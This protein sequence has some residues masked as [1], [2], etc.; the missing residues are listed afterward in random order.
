MIFFIST[1]FICIFILFIS[2]KS[3]IV[4]QIITCI[5]LLSGILLYVN[6]QDNHYRIM[7]YNTENYFDTFND[8]LTRDDDF[9]PTGKQF[10]GKTKFL[11][12]RNNLFK[13]ILALGEGN[14]P[15]AVGL[16]EIENRYVLNELCFNTPLRKYNYKIIH[17]ES[18][19]PRGID[20]ALL[21][22]TDFL[23]PLSSRAIH[24]SYSPNPDFKTRDILYT[25][26][27]LKQI[28]TLHLFI[29]HWPSKLSGEQ[30]SQP[31]RDAAA[32]A[33]RTVTDS[34][35]NYN[36]NANIIIMGD[37]ND[38][39]L[40]YSISQTLNTQSTDDTLK[41]KE[42]INL[43]AEKTG[44][45]GSHNYQRKW[46]LLDQIIVSDN[47]L[48]N[49]N[50]LNIYTKQAHIY[51]APFLLIKDFKSLDEKP[52][53]TYS[54]PRYLGGFSDHLPVWIEIETK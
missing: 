25:Q 51:K 20:V 11:K 52:F 45:E 36:P 43:M 42:L 44:K 49:E 34:I 33:L 19:D 2:Q 48:K 16:C 50:K 35:L 28:D 9:T 18:P 23:K 7:F 14:P 32:L 10:W 15:I 12:K 3:N 46:S 5:Y 1:I 13:V 41:P 26:I 4:K 27:L 8:S 39:P 38:E 17:Y 40:S 31:L 21:Y 54:G 22:R 24:V 29:N 53:R 6:G 37:F 30:E 47:L